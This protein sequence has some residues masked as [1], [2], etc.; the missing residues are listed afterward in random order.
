MRTTMLKRRYLIAMIITLAFFLV[1]IF[2]GS[3]LTDTRIKSVEESSSNQRMDF[4]SLQTQYLFLSFLNQQGNC[5]A[6]EETLNK[7]ILNLITTQ[8]RLE[9]YEKQAKS[10]YNDFINLKRSY[11]LAEI[12][13][14]LLLKNTQNICDRDVVTVLYFYDSDANCPKCRT[15]GFILSY[16]K[17]IFN[18]RLL[19]FSFDG[20]FKDEPIIEI[21]KKSYNITTYPSIVINDDSFSGL[22]TND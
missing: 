20:E 7:N 21:I 2:I 4:E 6:V 17:K 5:K 15:Q 19:I 9:N 8:E 3:L 14:W 11:S 13:Y 10:N 12:K 18:E 22:Q 16:L 1:G